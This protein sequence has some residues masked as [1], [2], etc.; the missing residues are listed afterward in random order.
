MTYDF[1]KPLLDVDGQPTADDMAKVLKQF[2]GTENKGEPVK[3]Y[4]WVKK[5]NEAGTL[6][7]DKADRK[8]LVDLVT[9]SDRM[10]ALA[11]GQL[12]EILEP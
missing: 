3:L 7:L 9:N 1:K 2:L 11:K 10:I 12:L 4:G 8:V 5:L 6:E